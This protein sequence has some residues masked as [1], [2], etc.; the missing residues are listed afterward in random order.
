MGIEIVI[1]R[2]RKQLKVRLG[3]ETEPEPKPKPEPEFR[4]LRCCT[5]ETRMSRPA[6]RAR[7]MVFNPLLRWHGRGGKESCRAGRGGCTAWAGVIY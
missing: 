3:T 6:R 5:V 2:G 1:D 7:A 4:L